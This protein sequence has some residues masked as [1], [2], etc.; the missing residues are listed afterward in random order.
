MKAPAAE[1]VAAFVRTSSSL[2]PAY[3]LRTPRFAAGLEV[4][5]L[6]DTAKHPPAECAGWMTAPPP[7]PVAAFVQASAAL[8]PLPALRPR[9]VD[10]GCNW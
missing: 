10:A 7:E 2:A 9:T 8:A 5:A 1:P 3:T 4:M 6:P